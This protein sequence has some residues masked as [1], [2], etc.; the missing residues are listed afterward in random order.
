MTLRQAFDDLPIRIKLIA[1]VLTV[2]FLSVS[3]GIS[4]IAINQIATFRANEL[5][6]LSHLAE[7]VA[8]FSRAPLSFGDASGARERLD[9][10]RNIP[11]IEQALILDQQQRVF[12]RWQRNPQANSP[13]PLLVASEPSL[14]RDTFT[15][16][17]DI[18]RGATKQGQI[19]LQANTHELGRQLVRYFGIVLIAFSIMLLLALLFAITLQRAISKPLTEL[20]DALRQAADQDDYG[21]RVQRR[22][23][24]ELGQLY[25]GFNRLLARIQERENELQGAR[26]N[27]EKRVEERTRELR[28]EIQERREAEQRIALALREKDILL[29]EIHHRV[30]NNLQIIHGLLT[31]QSAEPDDDRQHDLLADSRQRIKAMALVHETL[32]DSA[33]LARIDAREFIGKLTNHLTRLYRSE[34]RGIKLETHIDPIELAIDHAVPIGLIV[35]ELLTNALKYAFPDDRDGR[36]LVELLSHANQQIH[37]LVADNG[38]GLP[39][40]I[41]LDQT[42]TLGLRLVRG[43]S[44]Q[45]RAEST[46]QGPPGCRFEL[47]FDEAQA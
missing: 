15:I 30:K 27:L 32:Y 3:V 2:T 5:N 24:D 9:Y 18:G 25:V 6:R 28:D 26:L 16:L 7:I 29:R 10:L 40:E 45:L 23:R 37:L 46:L 38:I 4:L 19:L 20:A 33:D 21:Q 34:Q 14:F 11:Q 22:S 43:L 41:S 1:L 35:N 44:E 36:I 31:L 42:A 12:T 39:D 47:R 13:S 8:D 17:R